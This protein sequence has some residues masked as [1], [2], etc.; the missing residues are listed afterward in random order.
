MLR[1]NSTS[2]SDFRPERELALMVQKIVAR[3]AE[4]FWPGGILKARSKT[5]RISA[6]E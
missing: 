6:A 4:T 2:R 5:L 3:R 1:N